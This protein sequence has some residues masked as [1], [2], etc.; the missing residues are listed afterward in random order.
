[1]TTFRTSRD[2]PVSVES[3]FAAIQDPER[4]ARWW[5]P[6][7]FTNS[8]EVFEFKPGGK[9]KFTMHGPNGAN[10]P[11]ESEFAEIVTGSLVR[12]RHVSPPHFVLSIALTPSATGTLVSW[13]Q[14][15]A[16]PAIAASV[17]H[18]VEPANEQ[19]LDRLAAEVN[20]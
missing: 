4:L 10:Y 15:F 6:K 14:A 5:G 3:V 19:N 20:P 7:D 17:R 18:I 1:M 13:E 2:L 8:F 9:W 16:D 12:I 11:N